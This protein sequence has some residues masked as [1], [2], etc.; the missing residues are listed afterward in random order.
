MKTVT[1]DVGFY[2]ARYYLSEQDATKETE[3]WF[4]KDYS[5]E[6]GVDDWI[7]LLND[8]SIFTINS[9]QIMKRLKDYGG[10]CYM[11]ATFGEIWG[12]SQFL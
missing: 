10:A 6:L 9:L 1:I 12:K 2:L 5:P 3:E 8:S 11:Q 4:P 7:E